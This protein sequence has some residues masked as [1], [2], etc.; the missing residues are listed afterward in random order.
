MF[1][2]LIRHA[3][4]ENRDPDRWPDDSERPLTDQGR[5]AH[6]D[7]GRALRRLG[8]EPETVFTSPWARARETAEITVQALR[9]DAKPVDCEPLAAEPDLD[10]LQEHIGPRADNAVVALVGHSPWME[11]LASLLLG[12][13]T[14]RV[15]IDFPK[16]GVVGIDCPLL[17]PGAG[18]LS[19]M[20]RPKQVKK[21]DRS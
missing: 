18:T 12:G 3:R 14:S 17:A 21:L 2:L 15:P 7:V 1:L 11:E 16:S 20:L 8:L 5:A 4:A 9:L 6:A 13:A 10:A 19:F